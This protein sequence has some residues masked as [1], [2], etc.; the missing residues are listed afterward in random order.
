MGNWAFGKYRQKGTGY[1]GVHS[2]PISRK[3]G[4]WREEK[5]EEEEEEEEER[6]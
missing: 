4:G 6:G 1:P 5:V 2:K 3:V